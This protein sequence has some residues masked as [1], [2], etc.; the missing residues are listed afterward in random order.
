MESLKNNKILA[1]VF[2]GA[3]LGALALGVLAYFSYSSYT[4]SLTELQDVNRKLVSAEGAKLYP[5]EENQNK[6]AAAVN[7]YE[8]AVGGLTQVLL[9]LQ[10]PAVSILDTEFQAAL[11]QRISEVKGAADGKTALP[12]DFNLGFDAY[13]KSLPKSP[14]ASR[15]LNDYFEAVSAIV[16]ACID[17]G[18]ASIDTLERS[19]LDIEKPD[20]PPPPPPTKAELKAAKSK[21]R[22]KGKGKV[23]VPVQMTQVVERRQLTLQLTTDQTPLMNLMNTLADANQMPFFTV[24]RL[25]HIENEKQAGP[26]TNISAPRA[27]TPSREEPA[28]QPENDGAASGQAPKPAAV[29][30]IVPEKAASPDAIAVM[31]HEKLKVQLIIDIVRYQEASTAAASK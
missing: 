2:W 16:N 31:G 20:A 18:V 1:A 26:S 14:E 10:K 4:D 22:S 24:V 12:K 19:E 17:S 25:A 27:S 21:S 11:K 7:E 15:Q 6:L 28:P 30:V 9:H 3:L 5:N 23:A 13:T 29:E 8:G